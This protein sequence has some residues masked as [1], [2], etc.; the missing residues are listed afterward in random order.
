[1]IMH[2]KVPYLGVIILLKIF[3]G[4]AQ[5]LS[6]PYPTWKYNTLSLYNNISP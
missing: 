1:M 4:E 3:F 2:Q 6:I 5:P